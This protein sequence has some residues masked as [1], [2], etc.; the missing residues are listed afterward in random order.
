[1]NVGKTL[2][3]QVMEF[4]PWKGFARSLD[5][6]S[7]SAGERRMI[8]AEQFRVMAFAQLTWRKS[9]HDIEVTLGTNSNKLYAKGLRH[10]VHPPPWLMP[11]NRAIR[12]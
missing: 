9:L 3:S 5:R 2:V 7:A 11:T 12:A 1:M 10:E 6:Y 4:V 8:C